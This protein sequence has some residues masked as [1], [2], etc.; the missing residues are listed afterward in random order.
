MIFTIHQC[1]TDYDL[2]RCSRYAPRLSSSDM[3]SECSGAGRL[4]E[5]HT[6]AD[7]RIEIATFNDREMTPL[8]G[9]IITIS[10]APIARNQYGDI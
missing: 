2:P 1:H 5:I 3:P 4:F 7:G 9:T 6:R 8:L 10:N